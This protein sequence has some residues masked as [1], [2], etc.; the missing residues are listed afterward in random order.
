MTVRF[1][2]LQNS[3]YTVQISNTDYLNKLKIKRKVEK[4]EKNK[5]FPTKL[6][7]YKK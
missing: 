7:N 3:N 5:N 2:K 1:N 4:L 6:Q